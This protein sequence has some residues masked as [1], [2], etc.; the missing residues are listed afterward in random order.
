ML[1]ELGFQC[2]IGQAA[3]HVIVPGIAEKTNQFRC[4]GSIEQADQSVALSSITLRDGTIF[5]LLAAL[6]LNFFSAFTRS[7]SF[8]SF[9]INTPWVSGVKKYK[10]RF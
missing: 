10:T 6:L 9:I 5:H 7:S 4:Q 8:S 3:N 2:G 1:H